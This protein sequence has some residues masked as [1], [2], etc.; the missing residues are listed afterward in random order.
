AVGDDRVFAAAQLRDAVYRYGR[1]ALPGHLA[2]HCVDKAGEVGYLG[3]LRGVFDRRRAARA[4]RGEHDVLGG[5]DAGLCERDSGAL[6]DVG[7]SHDR[8]VLQ[9]YRR[10]ERLETFEMQIDGPGT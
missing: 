4:G 2:A 1:S 7:T 10:A 9:P 8:S 6:E 5:A 3:F